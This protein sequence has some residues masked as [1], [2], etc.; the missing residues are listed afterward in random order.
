MRVRKRAIVL[1]LLCLAGC[2]SAREINTLRDHDPRNAIVV[3]RLGTEL[4]TH[5]FSNVISVDR[6]RVQVVWRR[7]AP[8][9]PRAR[10]SAQ[11][12]RGRHFEAYSLPPGRYRISEAVL[13]VRDIPITTGFD[14]KSGAQTTTTVQHRVRLGH[15]QNNQ[16]VISAKAGDAIYIGDIIYQFR[17]GHDVF[18]IAV[19]DRFAEA[20]RFF[21]LRFPEAPAKLSRR[22]ARY[23]QFKPR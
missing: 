3:L 20:K 21:D 23:S 7:Y 6:S 17:Q 9:A 22:L 16:I 11:M 15:E 13:F 10:I 19:E 12:T 4:R 14:P 1:L 18:R 8:P 2:G 5:D